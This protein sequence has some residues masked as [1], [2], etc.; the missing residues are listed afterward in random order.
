VRCLFRPI[1]AG[2]SDGLDD[3]GSLA[4]DELVGVGVAVGV[5]VGVGVGDWL[6]SVP[7]GADAC[8]GDRSEGVGTCEDRE[9]AGVGA[10]VALVA[11]V[12]GQAGAF[13]FA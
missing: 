3:G 9:L 4:G 2:G 13:V 10:L 6:G 8:V 1:P 7:V 12:T 11:V 5:G